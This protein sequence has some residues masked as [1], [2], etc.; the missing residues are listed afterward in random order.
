MQHKLVLGLIICLI[1][2]KAQ[3]IE[4]RHSLSTRSHSWR[5]ELCVE[6]RLRLLLVATRLVAE[7]ANFKPFKKFLNML[8]LLII[9]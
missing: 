4:A 6:S 1:I 9:S 2:R 8:L 5:H 7:L 3:P